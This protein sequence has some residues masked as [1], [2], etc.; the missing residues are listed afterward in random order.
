MFT[1][2]ELSEMIAQ[3]TEKRHQIL[4]ALGETNGMIAAYE[5]VLKRLAPR[6]SEEVPIGDDARP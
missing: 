6:T 5:Q 1:H 2:D 4:I 3:L